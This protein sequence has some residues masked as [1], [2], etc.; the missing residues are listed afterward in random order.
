MS[1]AHF[2]VEFLPSAD[3]NLR[4]LTPAVQRRIVAAIEALAVNPRPPG[5]VK[6]AGDENLWRIRIGQWRVIYEIHDRRLVVL[7]VRVGHRKDI[8]RK[9]K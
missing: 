2:A 5:V 9:K 8:Y 4:R 1:A 3:R 7:V 6:L